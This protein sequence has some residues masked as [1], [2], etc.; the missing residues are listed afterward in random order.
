[1]PTT[2][3]TTTKKLV[4][5]ISFLDTRE[6]NPN[7]IDVANEAGFDDLMQ[8]AGR[9]KTTEQPNYHHFVN[10][11]LFQQLTI[12]AA[13][14]A[15]SGTPVLTIT[16]TSTGFA[17]R[18]LKLKFANGKMGYISSAVT[19][20]AQKDSFTVTS[21]DGTNLTAVDGNKM[22][23]AG[24]VMGEGSDEVDALT[25]GQTKYFNLVEHMK[26]KTEITDIQNASKVTVGGGFYAYIQAINQAQAFKS[27]ISATLIGGVKSTNEYGT[28]TPSIVDKDGK[29]MQT[30]GGLDAEIIGN[31]GVA[32]SVSST[33]T[34]ALTDYDDLLD[35]LNAVKAP[36]GYTIFTN[37][38]A[39]RKSDYM[40]KNMGSSNIQ[41]VRLNFDGKEI[42]FNADRVTYGNYELK[43]AYL[44]I[45]D[46]P[47]LFGGTTI[48]KSVYG[49]PD[50]RVKV[51]AGPGGRGGMEPRIGVRYMTN[52]RAAYNEG[53][54]IIREWY[55]GALAPTPTSGKEV[56]TVHY[57]TTQ[58]LEVLGA[59]QMF[60]QIVL[61]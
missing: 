38:K 23:P 3:G 44:K 10:E 35:Q 58:G 30:T 8:L 14:V 54:G 28:T 18:G 31:G 16:I 17:R 41:S 25:Y 32:D 55:T 21:V 4:S 2:Q 12:D 9:Y 27:Q 46:H 43:Y 52:G 42:D 61:S 20:N 40:W 22:N 5:A 34:V 29:P 37:D 50:G 49:I 33:G 48:A 57:S 19:T 11:D 36:H 47:H 45:L 15:G 56:L 26:D 1:M 7:I 59:K 51:Q 53:T 60:R 24:I 39:K 6:I 13:G